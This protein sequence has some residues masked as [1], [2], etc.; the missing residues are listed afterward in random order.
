MRSIG[1]LS[2]YIAGLVRARDRVPGLLRSTSDDLIDRRGRARR[3]RAARLVERFDP[4]AARA[5]LERSQCE[6]ICRQHSRLTRERS[7]DLR[8]AATRSTCVAGSSAWCAAR[9]AHRR[10]RRRPAAVPLRARSRLADGRGLGVAGVTVVERARARDRRG[11]PSRR[12]RRWRSADRRL[13]MRARRAY[14]RSHRRALPRVCSSAAWSC[15]SCR[16]ARDRGSGRSRLATASWSASRGSWSLSRRTSRPD[17]LITAD[18]ALDSSGREL[19]AVPGQV[20]RASG[21][22]Q[23]RA[24]EGR[25]DRRSRRRGCPRHALSASG[26]HDHRMH[27]PT[28]STRA[29]LRQVLDADRGGRQLRARRGERRT[30][31][32]ARSAPRSAD[33]RRLDSCAATGSGGYERCAGRPAPT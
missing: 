4:A 11:V 31:R 29:L 5:A 19:A 25:R 24:A 3:A 26:S 18:F 23:Q 22:G 12:G 1:F 20:T 10:D 28:R 32:R 15:R 8:P 14:P 6:A 30:A 17:P 13:G 33:S 7:R 16:R 9:G 2:P 27:G 21:R